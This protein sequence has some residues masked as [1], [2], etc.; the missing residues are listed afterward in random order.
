MQRP[1]QTEPGAAASEALPPSGPARRP[2]GRVFASPLARRL[3]RQVG[4][5]L[6]RIRGTG[7]GGRVVAR[8][9]RVL[10]LGGA[11]L[12]APP[13]SGPGFRPACSPADGP[14]ADAAASGFDVRP[15]PA[16]INLV[17]GCDLRACMTLLANLDR[18]ARAAGHAGAA[19]AIPLTAM[20]VKA[21][22]IALWRKDAGP[23]SITVAGSDVIEPRTVAEAVTMPL[24]RIACA[25]RGSSAQ[26]GDRPGAAASPSG[27]AALL[28]VVETRGVRQVHAPVHPPYAVSLALVAGEAATLTLSCD[29][30]KFG[31]GDA[32]ALVSDIRGLIESPMGILA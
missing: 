4:V 18:A 16:G 9:I 27:I 19:E 23:T 2:A 25:L 22:A 28:V 7:P 1:A 29:E 11:G 30:R 8:D 6:G 15:A 20:L 32:S 21:L 31:I 17:A 24:S 12:D 14:S 5:P 10:P 3:A 13:A 26:P